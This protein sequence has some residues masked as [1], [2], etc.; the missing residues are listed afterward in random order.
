M[1][2]RSGIMKAGNLFIRA[3]VLLTFLTSVPGPLPA[4]RV[5][6][7]STPTEVQA[8]LNAMTPE[9]RVGQL[10]LVTLQGTNINSES[11]IYDL[12]A[13]HHI[14]G[15][16]LLA[17][18]DNFLGAP[19]TVS[20]AHQMINTLQNIEAQTSE[21]VPTPEIEGTPLPQTAVPPEDKIYVPLFIGI[22]QE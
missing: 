22:S 12:I 21:G 8:V 17:E 14:G 2:E 19:D 11:Q 7:Q 10:F 15:V 13:N 5:Q 6:A 18:N 16:V 3:L 20:A 1:P 9:E 4:A